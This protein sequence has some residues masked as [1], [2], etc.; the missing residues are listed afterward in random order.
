MGSSVYIATHWR[1][2]SH[3]PT[4]I[5]SNKSDMGLFVHHADACCLGN[6]RRLAP[7][8]PQ[9]GL[10]TY[11][12]GGMRDR[13]AGWLSG[14]LVGWLGGEGMPELRWAGARGRGMVYQLSRTCFSDGLI[15]HFSHV[16]ATHRQHTPAANLKIVRANRP[17]R[18]SIARG[19]LRDLGYRMPQLALAI[20]CKRPQVPTAARS[21]GPP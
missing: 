19:W 4:Q 18:T 9:P 12:G 17:S 5:I 7:N 13:M 21:I 15:Q 8:A 6:L 1:A 14:L 20:A 16:I 10:S 11:L 3:P 2:H